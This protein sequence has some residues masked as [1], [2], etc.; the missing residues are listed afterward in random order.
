MRVIFVQIISFCY[1]KFYE[2]GITDLI[3][4]KLASTYKSYALRDVRLFV[5]LQSM[6]WSTLIDCIANLLQAH[7]HDLL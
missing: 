3:T 2:Y 1:S 7:S 5:C 4:K 6:N